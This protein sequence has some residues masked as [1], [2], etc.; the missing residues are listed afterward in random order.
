MRQRKILVFLKK[1]G[2]KGGG[3]VIKSSLNRTSVEGRNDLN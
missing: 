1:I 3:G 2:H